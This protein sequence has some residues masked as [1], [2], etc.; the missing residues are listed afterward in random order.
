[1]QGLTVDYAGL[2]RGIVGI[3]D[4]ESKDVLKAGMIPKAWM[5]LALE[6][7]AAKCD[8]EGVRGNLIEM[9]GEFREKLSSAL[10]RAGA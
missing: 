2:A 1:M 6:Q 10:L 9:V 8:R 5:N 4:E 3:M 7:F